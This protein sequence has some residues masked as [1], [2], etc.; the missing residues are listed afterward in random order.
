MLRILNAWAEGHAQQCGLCKYEYWRMSY[1]ESAYETA[2][3]GVRTNNNAYKLPC[4][5]AEIRQCCVKDRLE[6]GEE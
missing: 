4:E 3:K 1:T 6:D 2:I 5:R